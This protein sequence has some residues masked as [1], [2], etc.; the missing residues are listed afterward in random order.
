MA[1]LF[2]KINAAESSIYVV[3]PGI[4]E[5]LAE[6][7]IC[8]QKEKAVLINVCIDN[9]ED[10]I[11]NGYGDAAGIEKLVQNHI[12]VKEAKGNRISFIIVDDSG[13]FIFPESRIFTA[14][15]IG[16]NA[17][18]IDAYNML[19]LIS[20][21]FPPASSAEE[22]RF[23][24]YF[25]KSVDLHKKWLGNL[26]EE[27]S[28]GSPHVTEDF[29]TERFKNIQMAL[30]ND[31]PIEPDLQRK[32]KTYNARVQLAELRFGGG[33]IQNMLVEFP[34][35]GLPIQDKQLKELLQSRIKLINNDDFLKEN[36]SIKTLQARVEKLRKDFL[37]PLTCREGKSI[38]KKEQKTGFQKEVIEIDAKIQ[39]V[40]QSLPGIV[41]KAMAETKQLVKSN[42]QSFFASYP[43]DKQ[44]A[45]TDPDVRSY[46]IN[47]DIDKILASIKFPLLNKLP[48]I[49][50]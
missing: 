19:R 25:D 50:L 13:Y 22:E 30:K 8:I 7:L 5:E 43:T 1:L 48:N 26:S 21:Y 20:Y 2:N 49:F 18:E 6:L 34:K 14:D 11:R 29:D 17:Y 36:E 3:L 38:L 28:N 41:I 44:K 23:S 27:L 4:E 12:V 32:I 9:S 33:R 10:A 39:E 24:E 16:P 31:P 40:N 47:S 42:L 45:F 46:Q 37:I 35:K 15:P